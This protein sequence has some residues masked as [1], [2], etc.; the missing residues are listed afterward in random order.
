MHQMVPS[1]LGFEVLKLAEQ[2]GSAVKLLDMA[3]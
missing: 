2:E 3:I 1:I